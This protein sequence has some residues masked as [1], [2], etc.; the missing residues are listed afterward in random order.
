M[1]RRF[2]NL[3]FTGAQLH[4]NGYRLVNTQNRPVLTHNMI[5]SH[6]AFMRRKTNNQV[7]TNL[8][9]NIAF[10]MRNYPSEVSFRAL[11]K[12]VNTIINH[13]TTEQ[14]LYRTQH[15]AAMQVLQQGLLNAAETHMIARQAVPI[16]HANETNNQRAERIR[17]INQQY[18]NRKNL[19]T[20]TFLNT[21]E[22]RRYINHANQI[23]YWKWVKNSVLGKVRGHLRKA[24]AG[25]F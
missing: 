25:H 10:R 20:N 12:M 13:R 5:S 6:G 9:R 14:A 11:Q 21:N 22:V 23:S 18:R 3:Y 7:V 4:G 1:Q 19:L 15:N 24:R 2:K 16:L 8:A 17:L